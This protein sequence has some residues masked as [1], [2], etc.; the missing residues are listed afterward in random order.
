MTM[1]KKKMRL[2]RMQAAPRHGKLPWPGL[3]AKDYLTRVVTQAVK[4]ARDARESVMWAENQISRL[5]DYVPSE[6]AMILLFHEAL[7]RRKPALRWVK[8]PR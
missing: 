7:R 2:D 4:E 1:K 3:K 6:T 8:I 5:L